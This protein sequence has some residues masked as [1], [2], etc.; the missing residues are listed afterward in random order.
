MPGGEANLSFTF[1]IP[2][3]ASASLGRLRCNTQ[4]LLQV[5]TKPIKALNE[6]AEHFAVPE[7]ALDLA[8]ELGRGSRDL[9]IVLLE[10]TEIWSLQRFEEVFEHS[11]ALQ[12]VDKELRYASKGQRTL[13]NTCVVDIRPFRSASL[14]KQESEHTRAKLDEEAYSFLEDILK[15]IAPQVVLAAQCQTGNMENALARTLCSGLRAVAEKKIRT[16]GGLDFLAVNSFHPSTFAKDKLDEWTGGSVSYPRRESAIDLRRA[17]LKLAFRLSFLVAMNALV[18]REVVGLGIANLQEAI[19][20]NGPIC[21]IGLW[22]GEMCARVT[23]EYLSKEDDC[24]SES[25]QRLK[26]SKGFVLLRYTC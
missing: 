7:A 15:E 12:K 14:R 2:D 9:L 25:W 11:W 1:T 26:V 23:F 10:P 4:A 8:Q 13:R 22:H 6:C 18:G 16:C 21:N 20:H 17:L 3:T 5:V 24:S 19:K